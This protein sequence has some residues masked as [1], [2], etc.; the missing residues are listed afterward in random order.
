MAEKE[1]VLSAMERR[2]LIKIV[3]GR[4]GVLRLQVKS[5]ARRLLSE[6]KQQARSERKDEIDAF[7]VRADKIN[8]DYETLKDEAAALYRDI[9]H[10]GLGL[11]WRR[12]TD[13][14]V[15]LGNLRIPNKYHGVDGYVDESV[16]TGSLLAEISLLEMTAMEELLIGSLSS[17]AARE[18]IK[19][20]PTLESLSLRQPALKA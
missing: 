3:K 15:Y 18:Y 4:F 19:K 11:G 7:Q 9:T 10:V 1:D 5:E 12:D 20:L 14:M 17:T 6:A 2:E 16:V 8:A 13:P